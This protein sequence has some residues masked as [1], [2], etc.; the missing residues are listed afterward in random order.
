MQNEM[1]KT[2]M[3]K[4]F[5]EKIYRYVQRKNRKLVFFLQ[6]KLKVEAKNRKKKSYLIYQ[7]KGFFH[8]VIINMLAGFQAG[9][10]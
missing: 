5:K 9:L 8:S 2:K 10:T 3:Q 4:G 6:R 7:R 1:H